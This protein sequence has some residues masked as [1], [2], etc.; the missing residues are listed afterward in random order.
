MLSKAAWELDPTSTSLRVHQLDW[1]KL[2]SKNRPYAITVNLGLFTQTTH[3]K[4]SKMYK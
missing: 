3:F 4:A 1:V 2:R